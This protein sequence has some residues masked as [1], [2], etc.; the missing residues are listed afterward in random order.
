GRRPIR[1]NILHL[2]D[3]NSTG[4]YTLYYEPLLAP[5]SEAPHSAVAALF[6]NSMTEIPVQWSGDDGNGRGIAFFDV[7]ASVNG[8]PFLPWLQKTTSL[9]G[10]YHGEPGNRYAFYSVATD[11]A[12]NREATPSQADAQ[13]LVTAGNSPPVFDAISDRTINEGESLDMTVTAND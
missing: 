2:L 9:G 11:F 4:S 6:P 10:L 8:G 5:D 12:N 7:F 13:T 1:E 3:F